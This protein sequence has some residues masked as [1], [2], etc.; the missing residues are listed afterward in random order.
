MPFELNMLVFQK[1]MPYN[2]PEVREIENAAALGIATARGLANVVSTIWRRNLISDE[3]WT[4]L[5]D[6][7]ERGDDKVT[8]Y[9]WHR[10]HGFFYHPHPTRKNAFLMLHGGHGM[11]NLVI[12]PYNKVVFALIRNGLL[13]DAKAFKETTAFAESIIKK[14]CS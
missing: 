10:G 1:E 3:V 5:R 8:G 9:G 6:P 14:C 11:Q 7:V 12:D 4:Q 13:W 2:D